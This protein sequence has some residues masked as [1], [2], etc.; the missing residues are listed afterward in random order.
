MTG[1]GYPLSIGFY[2]LDTFQP[3]AARG[4][5]RASRRARGVPGADRSKKHVLFI[6]HICRDV[7]GVP[8]QTRLSE[9]PPSPGG[10]DRRWIDVTGGNA[11]SRAHW[12]QSNWK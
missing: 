7:G 6:P 12:D 1:K 3:Y 8:R 4:A 9:A 5:G 2:T 10:Q 11:K